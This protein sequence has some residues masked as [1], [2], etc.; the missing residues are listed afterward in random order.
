MCLH[1]SV[2]VLSDTCVRVHYHLPYKW[3]ILDG[4]T[5][6]DLDNV[7]E[8]E[9]AYCNPQNDTRYCCHHIRFGVD[10]CYLSY[11]I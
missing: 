2:V 3:Q 10:F 7:E 11:Q 5:W 8:I 1:V 9:K 6:R 4:V